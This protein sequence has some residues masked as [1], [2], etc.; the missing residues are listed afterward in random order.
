MNQDVVNIRKSIVRSIKE[1]AKV[2]KQKGADIISLA[3]GEPDFDTPK[4]IREV[5]IE[6]IQKG[7]THYAPGKGLPKLRREIQKKL[8]KDNHIITSEDNIIV[9]YGSK[10][11]VYLAVRTCVTKGDEVIILEPSWVS[12]AEIVR[13]SG[14]IP[15]GLM[16]DDS[17][18]YKLTYE[19]L[20][21][22]SSDKTR[23]LI[24][25]TPNNPTGK[26]LDLAEIKAI[27]R[28]ANERDVIV[29]SDEVYDKI[30][31]SEK[32][33]ISPASEEGLKDRTITVNG[34]SK[35][36]AMTGWRLGYLAAP[37]ELVSIINKLHIHT[38]TGTCPFIQEAATV[39]FQCEKEVEEMRQQYEK[40]RNV[41]LGKLN[42]AP[43][44]K[45]ITPEGAFY[46]W[47]RF[48]IPGMD[49]MQFAYWLLN[50]AHVLGIPGRAYGEACD[51]FIRFSF[52]SSLEDLEEAAERISILM[53]QYE[54]KIEVAQ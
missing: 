3:S 45:V 32:K 14:A 4:L 26:I 46:A 41:F 21:A 36:F 44:L 31:Y 16:L 33:V 52:A 23:M 2:L 17:D 50:E 37:S 13:S 27:E 38:H 35:T 7:N 43:Y 29:L 47:V 25:C 42:D 34:F 6:N 15:V 18:N 51:N 39:A 22:H 8:E 40:R 5:A 1:D 53:N 10:M 24:V 54:F 12:Y 9:T 19:K 30:V 11:A 49:S 48:D 28:F 20:I